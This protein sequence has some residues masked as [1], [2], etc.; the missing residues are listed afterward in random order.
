LISSFNFF[1]ELHYLFKIER[2]FNKA[3]QGSLE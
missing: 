3:I 1:K 2:L